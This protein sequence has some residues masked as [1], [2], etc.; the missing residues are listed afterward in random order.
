MWCHTKIVSPVV[1]AKV[2]YFTLWGVDKCAPYAITQK[3]VLIMPTSSSL[4]TPQA[5]KATSFG[6][7]NKVGIMAIL[8]FHW[9]FS[10][11]AHVQFIHR[12]DLR[13]RLVCEGPFGFLDVTEG[14]VVLLQEVVDIF[15]GEALAVHHD[16]AIWCWGTETVGQEP[17]QGR[18]VL[19]TE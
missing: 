2:I 10:P 1:A 11:Y 6:A 8:S 9:R 12:R 14:Q 5:V 16:A 7:A 3:R 19:R 15:S 13:F 17:L 4:V 18:E